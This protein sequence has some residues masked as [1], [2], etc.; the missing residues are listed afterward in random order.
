MSQAG[1]LR[2]D[3]TIPVTVPEDFVT[4]AGTAVSAL[5]II[6]VLGSGSVNTTGAGNTVTINSPVAS[7][8]TDS[9]TATALNGVVTIKGAG[10]ATTSGSGNAIVI[11][12]S[13][14]GGGGTTT[15]DADLGVAVSVANTINILGSGGITTS[16]AGNTLTINENGLLKPSFSAY[17]SSTQNNVTGDGTTYQVICDTEIFDQAANYNNATGIFT[18]PITGKYLFVAG[19][20]ITNMNT[21]TSMTLT[22]EATSGSYLSKNGFQAGNSGEGIY[23]TAII[24]M[25]AGDTAYMTTQSAGGGGGKTNA[26]VG[27]ANPFATYFQGGILYQ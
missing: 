23:F 4:D 20:F 2:Q 15:F 24:P 10:T 7:Y 5:N 11:T 22:I 25:T 18:A 16:A 19:V 27:Q 9:G 26:V 6:N 17:L 1:S 8:T 13:G 21:Q 12:T 3:T 14:S